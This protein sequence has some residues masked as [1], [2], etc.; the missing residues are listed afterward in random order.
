MPRGRPLGSAVRQNIIEILAVAGELHGYEVYRVYKKLFP[1]VTLRAI[2]Y[3]L[4]KGAAT[5]ELR[6]VGIRKQ[7]GA[8]SWGGEVERIYYA[9]GEQ[10]VV[11]GNGKVRAYFA[12]HQE[13][14]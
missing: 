12:K 6:V 1:A 7:A 10:A 3:H 14:R 8:Y 11:K 9:L 13:A 5:G 2:Y 4:K